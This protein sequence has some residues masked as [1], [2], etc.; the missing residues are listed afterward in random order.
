METSEELKENFPSLNQNFNYDLEYPCFIQKG[1]EYSDALNGM[2]TD[3]CITLEELV[4]NEESFLKGNYLVKD[5]YGKCNATIKTI[6]DA[7]S[8]AKRGKNY[9]QL[10]KF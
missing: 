10:K 3:F 9:L 7:F 5:L 2:F 8:L 4:E 1:E 6:Y